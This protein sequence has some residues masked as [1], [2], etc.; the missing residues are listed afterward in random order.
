MVLLNNNHVA[1]VD[2]KIAEQLPNLSCLIL[3]NNRITAL[4]DIDNLKGCE[5]L[6]MLSLL[7]N[8]V[9]RRQHYRLYVIHTL[10]SLTT[11]DYQKVGVCCHRVLSSPAPD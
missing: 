5:K 2:A 10:P 8:P 4:S 3:T 9:I 6:T 1:K 11:L 7:E